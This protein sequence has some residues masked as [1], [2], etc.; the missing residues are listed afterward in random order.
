ME[1]YDPR[2]YVDGVA[3]EDLEN[4]L[5]ELKQHSIDDN[6]KQYLR[7]LLRLAHYHMDYDHRDKARKYVKMS[8]ALCL[9]TSVDP[10][11]AVVM[12]LPD[13]K[14]RYEVCDIAYQQWKNEGY[15]PSAKDK[16]RIN[17]SVERNRLLASIVRVLET[18]LEEIRPAM[19]PIIEIET[20][21]N[22]SEIDWRTPLPQ[23]GDIP[24]VVEVAPVDPMVD[25]VKFRLATAKESS[26]ALQEAL[27]LYSELIVAQTEHVS[28][29]VVIF[30]AALLL[31]HIGSTAQAMEYFEFLTDEPPVEGKRVSLHSYTLS[32]SSKQKQCSHSHINRHQHTYTNNRWLHQTS[33]AF[34]P[35]LGL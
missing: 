25:I 13:V 30:R 17:F 29:D 24:V 23:P 6:H 18:V 34:S 16:I 27:A 20:T 10:L 35:R 15:V 4:S 26:G 12:V 28:L 11:N 32:Y 1:Y 7:A 33:L 21:K 22:P 19:A 31:K 2:S 14:N 3:M 9:P 5:E 8:I